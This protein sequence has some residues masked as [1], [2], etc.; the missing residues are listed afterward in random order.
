[1]VRLIGNSVCPEAA[2]AVVGA[3]FSGARPAQLELVA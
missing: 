2:E 3:Q 1:M